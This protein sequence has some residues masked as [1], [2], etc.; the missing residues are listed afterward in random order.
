MQHSMRWVT[1]LLLVAAL[2]ACG[3]EDEEDEGAD[4][5]EVDCSG[6]VPAFDEVTAFSQVC[7]DCHSTTL[8]GDDR[9]GAP[10]T[11]NW[12]D[13]DSAK[14]NAEHGA[15]EV[16]EGEMPP[17]GSGATLTEAQKEEIYLWSLCDTPE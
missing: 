12:D 17:E 1:C 6:D 16:F 7:A 14:A 13:Y 4:L 8:S 5:P 10:S 15:E 11:I 3:S 9:N 2:A